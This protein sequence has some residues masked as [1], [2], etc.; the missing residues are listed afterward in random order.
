[1]QID[2]I[3]A[4]H[5]ILKREFEKGRAPIIE[6][7]Q[8]QTKDPFKVLVATILSSRTKDETTA[9]ATRRL[10]AEVE[11]LE[12]LQRISQGKLEKL[13][14]PVGFY[15]V[16]AKHLK[17]LPK[18]LEKHFDGIIP[19]TVEELCE[20][21]GVGRKTA[22]LVVSVAFDLPAIC[23]DVHVHRISNRMGLLRTKTPLDTEMTLRKILP[24]RYWQSWNRFLVSFG[25]TICK[26][27]GPQC[28]E[29]PLR[30]HCDR[31]G[32]K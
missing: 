7:I 12:D 20:L 17:E 21:P 24:K 11:T 28:N 26:P 23:V 9:A 15:R 5:R 10:F 14:F 30:P 22:N 27:I 32:V 19:S 2:D 8:A 1:M 25:Q 16:K 3:P 31:V 29:C 6:L 13:I 4:V 18:A